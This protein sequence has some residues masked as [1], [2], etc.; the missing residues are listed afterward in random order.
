MAMTE[1]SKIIHKYFEA[2]NR[3]SWADMQELLHP[4]V[5]H[6]LNQG[7]KQKGKEAFAKFQTHMAECYKETLRDILIFTTTVPNRV[8]AEFIVEGQYLKTDGNLPVARNQKYTISAGSFF[9]IEDK[10]I[11]RITTYYNLKEWIDAVK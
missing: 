8:A 2:F 5:V 1:S 6:E 3:G 10:L 4:N 7:A 9:E 11:R